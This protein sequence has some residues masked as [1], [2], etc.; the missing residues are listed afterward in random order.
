MPALDGVLEDVGGTL[1]ALEEVVVLAETLGGP[2]V[3]V[4]LDRGAACERIVRRELLVYRFKP[5]IRFLDLRLVTVP[6][7]SQDFVVLCDFA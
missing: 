4:V 1:D 5:T 7:N 2:L 6:L 3:G